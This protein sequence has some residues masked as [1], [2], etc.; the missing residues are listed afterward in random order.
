MGVNE[1]S[2]GSSLLDIDGTLDV[3]AVSKRLG[4]K[5]RVIGQDGEFECS[6]NEVIAK[7]LVV[8]IL[9]NAM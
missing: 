1:L 6:T 4:N 5:L 3:Y 2:N 7:G 9:K 8:V